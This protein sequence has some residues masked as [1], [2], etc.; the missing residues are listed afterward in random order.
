MIISPSPISLGS[1]RTF[2]AVLKLFSGRTKLLH[3]SLHLSTALC[4]QGHPPCRT[5]FIQDSPACAALSSASLPLTAAHLITTMKSSPCPD[6]SAQ[7]QSTSISRPR[8]VLFCRRRHLRVAP[9]T[10][11]RRS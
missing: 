10:L 3:Q 1:Q 11:R 2:S 7:A 5:H 9:A 8:V 6:P 4:R